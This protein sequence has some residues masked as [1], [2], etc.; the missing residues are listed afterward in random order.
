MEL[1]LMPASLMSPPPPPP[2]PSTR[3]GESMRAGQVS[4]LKYM[5][6]RL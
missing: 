2:P 1:M 6:A 4:Q 5:S 3:A